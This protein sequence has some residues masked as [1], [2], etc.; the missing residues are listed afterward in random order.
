M[1]IGPPARTTTAVPARIATAA[2]MEAR[3]PN[4]LAVEARERR[5]ATKPAR[6]GGRP[7][8]TP[9]SAA[10]AVTASA[11]TGRRRHRTTGA[12]SA[13]DTSRMTSRGTPGG[14]VTAS[15]LSAV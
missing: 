12:V 3:G 6:D 4:A 13:I 10:P 15:T 11:T 9:A 1:P 7:T 5:I 14:L 8:A 2:G